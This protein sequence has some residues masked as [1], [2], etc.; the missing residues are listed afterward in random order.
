MR[1]AEKTRLNK[2][3]FPPVFVL[4]YLLSHAVS[5]Q[6]GEPRNERAARAERAV[7]QADEPLYTPFVE[8]YILDELKQLRR[9]M[10]QQRVELIQQV[11]DRELDVADKSMSYATNTVTYFFYLIVGASSLLVLVGWTSIRDI[12]RNVKSYANQEVERITRRYERRMQALERE[13]HQKSRKI[14]EAQDEIGRTNEVHSLWL[15]ASQ[16]SNPQAKIALYDQI[17]ELRPEDTEALTFKADM[18]LSLE[19]PQWAINLADKALEIDPENAH[20]F[21]Q[22][23]CAHASLENYDEA[24]DDLGRA[25]SLSAG[26]R[27]EA[28][29]DESFQTFIN[30]D[31]DRFKDLVA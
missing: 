22:R 8:R 1:T 30:R 11:T 24:L 26:L 12:R 4:L 18:V 17:L 3:I 5:A 9:E 20:A 21:Y 14:T 2:L 28:K 7:N 23:A 25:I 31:D 10:S 13:L 16:E 27:E 29:K 19:E 6:E 15:K